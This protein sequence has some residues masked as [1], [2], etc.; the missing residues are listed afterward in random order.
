MTAVHRTAQI[1]VDRTFDPNET[2]ARCGPATR[3]QFKW[4]FSSVSKFTH[5]HSH[6]YLC[7]HCS[8]VGGG[9]LLTTSVFNVSRTSDRR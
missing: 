5:E 6:L 1:D 3:A 7:A 8:S 2:C 9:R 4:V